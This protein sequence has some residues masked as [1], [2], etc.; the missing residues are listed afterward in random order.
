MVPGRLP[1]QKQKKLG[2]VIHLQGLGMF[3]NVLRRLISQPPWVT[4]PHTYCVESQLPS[5]LYP[6]K[7][8]FLCIM[9]PP[10]L[11]PVNSTSNWTLS[12]KRMKIDRLGEPL[13]FY[14]KPGWGPVPL[15]SSIPFSPSPESQVISVS[16]TELCYLSLSLGHTSVFIVVTLHYKM[17]INLSC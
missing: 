12:V 17:V 5:A 14:R 15:P 8:G 4:E 16:M 9:L 7:D 13:I 2:S 1:K 3:G 10:R 11:S 6:G